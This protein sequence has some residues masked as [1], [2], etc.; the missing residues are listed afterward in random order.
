[1]TTGD[2]TTNPPAERNSQSLK[3]NLLQLLVES[4]NSD[5]GWGYHPAGQSATEA[6]AWTLWALQN[7][8]RSSDAGRAISLGKDWLLRTQLAGGSWPAFASQT[9]GC[10]ATSL[11]C[12]AV[13]ELA[14]DS[15][16]VEHGLDWLCQTWPRTP[17]FWQRLRLRL[18]PSS[19]V[20]RQDNSLSGWPWTANT[21]SWVEPTSYALIFMRRL[22][23]DRLSRLALERRQLA[24]AMLC[25]RMCPGG[26]W[27]SG[28]PLVY[29]VAGE[30]LVGPTVWAL[31]ALRDSAELSQVRES[32]QWLEKSMPQIRGSISIAI[33]HMC[34]EV[35]G[36]RVTAIESQ[37]QSYF[38]TDRFLNNIPVM[39][40]AALALNPARNLFPLAA[41]KVAAP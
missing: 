26:G 34:L 22:A 10:W 12:L 16:A 31:L 9:E 25:D 36:R 2:V 15:R 30:P 38:E 39:A 29:G 13:N 4:Q 7:E 1:V 11:A 23:P 28:N 35:Y 18:S 14:A 37:L 40:L 17:N 32:L 6:T 27:N 5:G 20:T 24:E 41:Q 21:S 3:S 8:N 33:A 19:A